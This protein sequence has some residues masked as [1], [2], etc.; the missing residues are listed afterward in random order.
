MSKL[1][2]IQNSQNNEISKKFRKSKSNCLHSIIPITTKIK[3]FE[4]YEN[5]TFEGQ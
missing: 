3:Y 5:Q 1:L 2:N 4:T